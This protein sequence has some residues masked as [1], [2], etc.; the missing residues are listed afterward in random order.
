MSYIITVL[1]VGVIA[2]VAGVLVGRKNAKTVNA[3]VNAVNTVANSA[4]AAAKSVSQATTQVVD[5][6]KKI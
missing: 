2:F 3:T 5:A 1:I 4:G 6:V